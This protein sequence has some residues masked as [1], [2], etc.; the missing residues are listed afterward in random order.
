MDA[1]IEN[2]MI[3]MTRI[4]GLHGYSLEHCVQQCVHSTIKAKKEKTNRTLSN[5]HAEAGL[6]GETYR[7]GTPGTDGSKG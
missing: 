1:P 4:L 2:E 6:L 7:I 5:I 3:S